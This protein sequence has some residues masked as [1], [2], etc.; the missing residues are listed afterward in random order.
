MLCYLASVDPSQPDTLKP[1]GEFRLIAFRFPDAGQASID[2]AAVVTHDPTNVL[3]GR[4]IARIAADRERGGWGI[5]M[6]GSE[7]DTLG[8]IVMPPEAGTQNSSAALI[9]TEKGKADAFVLTGACG[10]MPAANA[11]DTFDKIKQLPDTRT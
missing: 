9:R 4:P 2:G 1:M 7:D 3:M 8:L 5:V 10:M 11:A 6:K